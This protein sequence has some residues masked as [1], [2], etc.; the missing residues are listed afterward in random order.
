M[1]KEGNCDYH[2]DRH[3][4]EFLSKDDEKVIE[5]KQP[6]FFVHFIRSFTNNTN[7]ICEVGC[8]PGRATSYLCSLGRN[9]TAVDLSPVSVEL[10]RKRAGNARFVIANNLSLPFESETFD[11]VV[12]DGVIHHTGNASS[13]FCE[14]CRILKPGGYYYLCM[15]RNRGH[16]PLVYNHIGPLVRT[17]YR[18]YVGRVLIE[19]SLLPLY[20]M[21]HLVK[22]GGKARYNGSRS[23]FYNYIVSPGVEFVDDEVVSYWADKNGLK[24]VEYCSNGRS[25]CKMSI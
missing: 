3:P 19:V 4:F 20:H 10:A 11:I 15:Y 1:K 8:G 14:N 24:L 5:L 6:E 22:S 16:Y 17:L 2:Y 23:F 12:S 7:L 25:C 13:A 21:V 18:S 9:V